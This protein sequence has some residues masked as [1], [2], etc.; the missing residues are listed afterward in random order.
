MLLAVTATIQRRSAIGRAAWKSS[1]LATLHSVDAGLSDKLAGIS[2]ESEMTGQ[3][4][5]LFVQLVP[6]GNGGWRLVVAE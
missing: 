2:R 5:E 3:N 4:K 1:S 6:M